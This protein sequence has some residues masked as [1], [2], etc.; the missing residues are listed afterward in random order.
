[1]KITVHQNEFHGN[2]I[3]Y[4]GKSEAQ[5]IKAARRHDCITCQCGG[6]QIV[7]SDG[8]QLYD[9][10]ITQPFQMATKPFWEGI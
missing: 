3:Y 9:W 2:Q 1:M 4:E 5:A 8:F 6:P 7:R 10:H